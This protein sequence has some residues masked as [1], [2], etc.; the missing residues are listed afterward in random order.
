VSKVL[1]RPDVR[2]TFEVVG[3]ETMAS[4]PYAAAS[5]IAQEIAKWAKVIQDANLR[6]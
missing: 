6:Q 4:A 3:F 1:E 5:R 2:Q